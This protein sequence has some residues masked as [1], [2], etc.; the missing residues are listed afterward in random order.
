[1][2]CYHTFERSEKDGV[3][4]DGMRG[5]VILVYARAPV[6]D[7]VR[8][9]DL[10]DDIGDVS[11]GFL[12]VRELAIPIR[13]EDRFSA[14]NLRCGYCFAAFLLPVFLGGHIGI[15]PFAKCEMKNGDAITELAVPG[16][17]GAARDFYIA[18]MRPN[19]EDGLFG[20]VCHNACSCLKSQACWKTNRPCTKS[21]LG[22]HPPA[23]LS[24]S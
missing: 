19:C 11:P 12:C 20:F 18:A 6:R 7:D 1:M 14:N 4:H 17:D 3:I 15:P 13:R 5:S 8:R 9:S 2:R 16:E 10:P 24:E 23:L 21:L 22:G